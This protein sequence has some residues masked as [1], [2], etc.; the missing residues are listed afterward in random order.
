MDRTLIP[1]P[2][3][4]PKN[5]VF[6]DEEKSKVQ[7]TPA[8]RVLR[9]GLA[10]CCGEL[11]FLWSLPR[12]GAAFPFTFDTLFLQLLAK[13]LKSKN[14]DDLQE[15]NKLI[16][17]M[18]KEVSGPW[19]LRNGVQEPKK[20]QKSLP[21]ALGLLFAPTASPHLKRPENGIEKQSR[22]GQVLGWW[23]AGTL[24]EKLCWVQGGGSQEPD[25]ERSFSGAGLC[26]CPVVRCDPSGGQW[27][28]SG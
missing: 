15:A 23:R 11:H 24:K 4:R 19:A 3:P 20:E 2:P 17:S 25:I 5:P 26:S 7:C 9:R 28:E 1:S 12:W 10:R 27:D 16:K 8:C 6:D 14:P 18:V 21:L 22:W 13:L